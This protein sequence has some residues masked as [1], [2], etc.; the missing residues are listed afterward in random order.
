MQG[1]GVTFGKTVD[2]EIIESALI[3]AIKRSYNAVTKALL[4][5]GDNSLSVEKIKQLLQLASGKEDV[6]ELLIQVLSQKQ[7]KNQIETLMVPALRFEQDLNNKRKLNEHED[8]NQKNNSF[9]KN[10][11]K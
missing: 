11:K 10:K 9:K 1:I 6:I 5:G 2:N 3:E 7:E 8:K 4:E